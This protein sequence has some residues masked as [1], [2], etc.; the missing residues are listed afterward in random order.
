MGLVECG[1]E[2]IIISYGYYIH[3]RE[4]RKRGVSE[5]RPLGLFMNESIYMPPPRFQFLVLML[6]IPTPTSSI[7]TA[8]G[9]GSSGRR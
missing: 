2:Y 3:T 8:A 5:L 1:Y 4:A 6:M 9:R 7:G